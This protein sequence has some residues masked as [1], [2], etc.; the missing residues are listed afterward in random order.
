MHL[1]LWFWLAGTVL[2]LIAG[3]LRATQH[4][5]GD[6]HNPRS[7]GLRAPLALVCLALVS[8]VA[9]LL[10]RVLAAGA[11]PG[12]APADGVAVL[13]AGSL[14]ILVWILIDDSRLVSTGEADRN[15]AP[16]EALAMWGAGLL[17]M[18]AIAAAWRGTSGGASPPASPW[19]F[20]LRTAAAGVGLGAWLPTLAEAVWGLRLASLARVKDERSMPAGLRAMLAGYPWL[21]LAWLLGAAWSLAAAAAL[22][23][24]VPPEAWLTAAWLLGGAYLIAVSGTIRPPQ[25]ALVLVAALGTSAAL[26]QAWQSSLLLP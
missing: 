21:T 8:L 6:N 22:W 18:L 25:W 11:Q 23:R 7:W 13:A 1:D 17:V 26:L 15:R 14:A 19:L 10:W 20:G 12:W 5:D 2:V 24:G 16:A 4:R 3:G 9:G